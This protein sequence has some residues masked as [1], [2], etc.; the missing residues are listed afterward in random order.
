MWGLEFEV[1]GLR[2]H[3]LGSPCWGKQGVRES[4][5]QMFYRDHI[6]FFSTKHQCVVVCDLRQGIWG[7]AFRILQPL[8]LNPR[9]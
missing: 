5:I 6:P 4:S 7:V 2:F 8:T 9:P 1:K 3:G